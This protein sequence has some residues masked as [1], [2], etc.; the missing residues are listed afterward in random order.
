[1]SW[2]IVAVHA[3][4]LVSLEIVLDKFLLSSKKV[5]HPAIYA[6]YSGILSLFVV[7]FI[8]FGFHGVSLEQGVLSILFGMIFIYGILSLFFAIQKNEASRVMPVVGAIIPITTYFTYDFFLGDKLTAYQLL[9]VALLIVGGLLISFDLPLRIKNSKFFSGAAYAVLAG[10][11]IALSLDAFKIFYK[12]DNFFNVFIWTRFGLAAGAL[13]LLAVPY[14]RKV[15]LG[16]FA[17][18]KE[19]KKD[20]QKTGVLFV[21]NKSLGGI[22]SI[23]LNYAIALGSVTIVN[24]LVSIEYVF[25][26][27]LGLVLSVRY[28]AIFQEKWSF[29]HIVQ[30]VAA[31]ATITVG[32]MLVSVNSHAL[33]NI[34]ELVR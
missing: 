21:V 23:M 29:G 22:G 6:F 25:I 31:I 4:L 24:A 32:V 15:I 17:S 5:S 18:Y 14:G 20:N 7:V 8:P 16:S 2:I 30:K 34:A 13:S 26:L 12:T 1:M 3:Y 10:I 11:L 19:N 27:L 28:P 33:K 9:G